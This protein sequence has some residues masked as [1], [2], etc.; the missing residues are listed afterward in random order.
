MKIALAILNF[1]LIFLCVYLLSKKWKATTD[2]LFWSAFLL[3]LV[4]GTC[5]GL[6]YSYYYSAN[7]TWS[8]FN[9]AKGL[10]ILAHEN[11]FS[12]VNVLLEFSD[13]QD[14]PLFVN[15]DLRSIFFIKI[16]SVFCLVSGDNYWVC[17]AYFSLL[18][19]TASWQLHRKVTEI[20]PQS[21]W[22]SILAFL[23]FPSVIFWGSGL[24][25]ESVALSAI[26]FLATLFLSV[27]YKTKTPLWLWPLN[28]C[29]MV[30]VWGLKYYWAIIFFISTLT[31]LIANFLCSRFSI[32]DNYRI[33]VFA[34]VF[35]LL[36]FVGRCFHPNFYF[37]RFLEVLVS[38]H[39]EFVKISDRNNLIH[40]YQL[41]PSWTSVFINS[42]L[43]LLSGMFRPFVGEG[44]GLLGHVASI[45]NLL[46]LLLFIYS[47]KNFNKAFR[48]QHQLVFL[49]VVSYA[50][51]L[52]VFLA[53]STP[54]FG[55]LSRYRVGFLPFIVF[56][57]SYR[58]PLLDWINKK[59]S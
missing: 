6:V 1:L 51:V 19:F 49:S 13:T 11:F 37:S 9:V 29:A 5:V 56:L 55:T 53:L 7:D 4:A 38:N 48:S 16:I 42:P 10:S 46:V 57:F 18:S 31:A 25:K 12:F 24:E 23:F 34:F 45:E 2:K 58:N 21:S 47:I 52:C 35:I 50:V 39:Q 27:F 36:A 15:H 30:A 44:Q 14:L 59:I 20:F 17:A 43:A 40:F 54:N 41:E 33:A 8:F 26:Y 22:A 32:K 3:R 28:A